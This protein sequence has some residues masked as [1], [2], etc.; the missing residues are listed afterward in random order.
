MSQLRGQEES[1]QAEWTWGGKEQSAAGDSKAELGG[2][3]RIDA[4]CK[5]GRGAGPTSRPDH[6]ADASP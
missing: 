5:G 6:F 2:G 3:G 1:G 4:L